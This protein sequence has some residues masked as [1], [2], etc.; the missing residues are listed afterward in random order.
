MTV[1]TVILGIAKTINKNTGV[2]VLAVAFRPVSES[3]RGLF[4]LHHATISPPSAPSPRHQPTPSS[5]RYNI[6]TQEASKTLVVVPES[7]VS[8]GGGDCLYSVGTHARWSFNFSNLQID[9]VLLKLEKYELRAVITYLCLKHF[10]TE[11]VAQDLQDTLGANAPLY[12]TIVHGCVEFKSERTSTKDDPRSG[13]PTTIVTEEMIKKSK[14]MFWQII[15]LR[16]Q[17][18]LEIELTFPTLPL[19]AST[20]IFSLAEKRALGEISRVP[21]GSSGCRSKPDE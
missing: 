5:I 4:P 11:R 14:K 10:T 20:Y 17:I 1:S 6:S 9:S 18:S 21:K 12:S 16:I 15:V 13:H 19:V 8:M 3:F 7:R 2:I